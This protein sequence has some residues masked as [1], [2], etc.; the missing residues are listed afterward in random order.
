MLPQ[1]LPCSQGLVVLP[2]TTDG[3]TTFTSAPPP[4]SLPVPDSPPPP[5]VML[6]G[7]GK[8][9]AIPQ[10]IAEDPH[11][12]IH[13]KPIFTE[14]YAEEEANDLCQH[15][16]E[17]EQHKAAECTKHQVTLYVWTAQG[18]KFLNFFLIAEILCKLGLLTHEGDASLTLRRYNHKRRLWTS[19]DVGHMVK[20]HDNNSTIFL[21]DSLVTH[22]VDLERH[23][24]QSHLSPVPNLFT[25]LTDEHKAVKAVQKSHAGHTPFDNDDV[26]ELSSTDEADE[27]PVPAVSRSE[28]YKPM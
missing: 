23:L 20:L 28:L 6:K 13:L 5:A 24:Q 18:F 27:P 14:A 3:R 17:K 19:F 8:S 2:T 1:A 9:H 12:A 25:N 11:Y 22:C 26:L 21:K 4:P 7:K 16:L 15:K 10:P